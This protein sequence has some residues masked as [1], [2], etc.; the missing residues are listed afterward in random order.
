MVPSGFSDLYAAGRLAPAN[1]RSL[2]CLPHP[3]AGVNT[4]ERVK[5][6]VNWLSSYIIHCY[7]MRVVTT[8]GGRQLAPYLHRRLSSGRAPFLLSV[9]HYR[10]QNACL[11]PSRRSSHRL[12]WSRFVPCIFL[13]IL[14][15][16]FLTIPP[17]VVLAQETQEHFNVTVGTMM[18]EAEGILA[19]NFNVSPI[20]GVS[21]LVTCYLAPFSDRDRN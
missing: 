15:C 12:R 4:I 13:Q 3:W 11:P 7:L 9:F 20:Q 10:L 5:R 19:F 21:L 2:D 17:P 16:F 18:Y 6:V 1:G 8:D 14:P